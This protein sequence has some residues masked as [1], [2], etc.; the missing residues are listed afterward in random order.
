MTSASGGVGLKN[1]WGPHV[2]LVTMTIGNEAAALA[3]IVDTVPA[4]P[5]IA[6]LGGGHVPPRLLGALTMLSLVG[7][8]TS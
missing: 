4:G 1:E 2:W 7:F 5:V 6:G 8:R 3:A